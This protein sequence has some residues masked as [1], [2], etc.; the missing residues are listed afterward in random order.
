MGAGGGGFF[1]FFVDEDTQDSFINSMSE[2]TIV[3]HNITNDPCK[4]IFDSYKRFD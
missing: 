1:L 3:K 2:F 4:V